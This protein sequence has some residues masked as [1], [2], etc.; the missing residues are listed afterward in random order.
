MDRGVSV[1]SD[2]FRDVLLEA[3]ALL[4]GEG[5]P[6]EEA[7]EQRSR[8]LSGFRW[9]L[10]DEYQDIGPEQ[11]ELISALAGRTLED[12]DGRLGIFAVGDDDQNI[13]DFQGASVEFIQRFEANYKA[14]LAFLMENYRSTRHIC[15][16]S[17]IVIAS[18]CQRMK[19]QHPI[20]ID[21]RRAKFPPG[22]DWEKI[23]PVGRGRVQILPAGSDPMS[24][25]MAVM[26][27]YRRLSAMDS[28][29]DWT[30]AAIIAREWKYLEPVRAY[31]EME[32][33][34]AQMAD[35]ERPPFWRLR[36]T[37]SLVDWLKT[38]ES[39]WIDP[40]AIGEWLKSNPSGPWWDLLRD[41]VEEYALETVGAELPV[42]HFIEWLAE[43][44][45][46][47]RRRQTGLMLLTA[48]RAKGLEFDHVIVLDGGWEKVGENHDVDS[49]RR[50]YYVAMTRARKTLSLVHFDRGHA[51][52]RSLP[53][54]SCFQRR[55]PT[56]PLS[57][58][59][60]LSRRYCRLPLKEID[61]SYAGRQA[62]ENTVH[63]AIAALSPGDE[64]HLRANNGRWDLQ[65]DVGRIVGRLAKSYSPPPGLK[66][67]SGQVTA[68]I[69][70]R[71][72]DTAPGYQKLLK[73]GSWEVVVPELV[74]SR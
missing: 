5:L 56:R 45:R 18:A 41:A 35:E 62:P 12:E 10:V 21:R 14:K 73:C 57:P 59:A 3:I 43:W 6:P 36:E 70:W 31:C 13:Y 60:E 64:I 44:G 38:Q 23:D 28:N 25:A 37:R 22:G 65:D 8:L 58:P 2:V 47:A 74:F 53:D 29:W 1:G 63:S 24:Q 71:M 55:T 16:A 39:R 61:L 30:R 68:A 15:D 9:I 40:S 4:K 48:H 17:N 33:I 42:G 32:G 72:E 52:L 34:P 54:S 67:V 49:S 46:E 7:D 19:N 27:E 11:Y 66:C 26:Q 50:L 69:Q 20:A 51:I